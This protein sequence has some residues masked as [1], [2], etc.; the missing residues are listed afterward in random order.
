MPGFLLSV[1]TV[2]HHREYGKTPWREVET[3]GP[4]RADVPQCEWVHLYGMAGG[5]AGPCGALARVR[6]S[7]AHVFAYLLDQIN[8]YRTRWGHQP[9]GKPPYARGALRYES[10]VL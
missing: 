7:G 3:R 8:D 2:T 4:T 9:L 1:T 10:R 5:S 6:D